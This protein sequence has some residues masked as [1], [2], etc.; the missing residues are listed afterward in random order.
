MSLP[1]KHQIRISAIL[2][3]YDWR[4]VSHVIGDSNNN[5]LVFKTF[6]AAVFANPD[7]RPLF[8]SDRGFQ[9][10][11][12]VFYAKLEQQGMT[13]SMSRVAKCIENGPMEGFWGIIKR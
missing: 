3:L 9:Y 4:I 11:N 8:H 13:Q 7:A 6:D 12:R 5:T 2:D 10:A 1:Q